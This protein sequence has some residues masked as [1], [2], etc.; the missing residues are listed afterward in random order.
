MLE[1][2]KVAQIKKFKKQS[3]FLRVYS[4]TNVIFLSNSLLGRVKTLIQTFCFKAR[5]A[6]TLCSIWL[7]LCKTRQTYNQ[8]TTLYSLGEYT[9]FILKI[10]LHLGKYNCGP[11]ENASY[12]VKLK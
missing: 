10:D 11:S 9:F 7:L 6:P 8:G 4:L 3:P 5:T 12:D 2:V 1:N